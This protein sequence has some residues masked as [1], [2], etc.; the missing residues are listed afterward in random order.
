MNI[1][2]TPAQLSWIS[3]IALI[4]AGIVLSFLG[5]P[6]AFTA[7]LAIGALLCLW[8]SQIPPRP[9]LWTAGLVACIFGI[10]FSACFNLFP[11]F[12][13]IRNTTPTSLSPT[14]IIWYLSGASFFCG[15]IFALMAG[16]ILMGISI[17]RSASLPKSVG[18]LLIVE[19]ILSI[20]FFL[21]GIVLVVAGLFLIH[22]ILKQK[23]DAEWSEYLDSLEK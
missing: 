1:K 16:Y 20:Y 22:T 23:K 15:M 12:H 18:V 8:A 7:I 3:A 9:K 6:N 10:L 11:I 17:L 19:G 13:E 4:L 21:A 2:F 14:N 5:Y